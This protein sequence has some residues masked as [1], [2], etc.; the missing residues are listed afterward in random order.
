MNIPLLVA[1]R[2]FMEKYPENSLRGLQAALE[3]GAP[4]IEF[5]IQSTADLELV[6]FH[7]PD[8]QRTTGTEGSLFELAYQ[9]LQQISAHEPARLGECFA[10][11]P[12]PRLAEISQ[13]L[14]RYPDA[15]ILP[16]IKSAT[17]ER[18]GLRPI[19]DRMIE[20]LAPLAD[21]CTII[22]YDIEAL[23]YARSEGGFPVGWVI[24]NYDRQT[25]ETAQRLQPDLIIGEV[26]MFT[27]EERPW[28]GPWDWMLYD[29]TDPTLALAYADNGVELIE[30]RDIAAMYQ[31]PLL[32]R[33]RLH[34]QHRGS[35]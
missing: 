24:T 30:T 23:A 31:D 26:P 10:P 14:Q 2:G 28:P 17:L 22:G 27:P 16:E 33:R 6:L 35:D 25:L 5:D 3:E 19:M 9:D 32:A 21:R 4:Y 15:Q 29:I 7:D 18:F 8:L 13:L 1:H 11:A 34:G 20:I 12:I